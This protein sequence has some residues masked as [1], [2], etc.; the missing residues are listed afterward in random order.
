ML[1]RVLF[2]GTSERAAR[3]IKAEGLISPRLGSLVEQTHGKYGQEHFVFA[4]GDPED[5]W[6]Y[7]LVHEDHDAADRGHPP[8]RGAVFVIRP[9]PESLWQ[10]CTNAED[11]PHGVELGDWYTSTPVEF[12]R[13][14]VGRDAIQ[15]LSKMFAKTRDVREEAAF[16]R[17]E[18]GRTFTRAEWRQLPL[19]GTM[20]DDA[21]YDGHPE[22]TLIELRNCPCGS[23]IAVERPSC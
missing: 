23:T 12:E 8:G 10:R 7:A 5:A 15:R 3:R 16:K 9:R 2:H 6:G 20:K 22:R 21:I 1:P 18:C 4:A 17:C 13:A 19:T 14:A 11:A